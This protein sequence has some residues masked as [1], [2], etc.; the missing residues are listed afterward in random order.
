MHS[1]SSEP[2]NGLTGPQGEMYNAKRAS[3]FSTSLCIQR[4]RD[5]C[6]SIVLVLYRGFFHFQLLSQSKPRGD[7]GSSSRVLN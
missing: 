5:Y 7:Q 4:P 2:D 6:S 1:T 3:L